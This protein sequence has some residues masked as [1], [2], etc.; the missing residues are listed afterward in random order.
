MGP[1]SQ[2]N[3]LWTVMAS[4]PPSLYLGPMQQFSLPGKQK[5]SETRCPGVAG[6]GASEPETWLFSKRDTDADGRQWMSE[7]IWVMWWWHLESSSQC[8]C[9]YHP[10]Y[11]QYA[12]SDG[13]GIVSTRAVAFWDRQEAPL[14]MDTSRSVF[15]LCQGVPWFFWGKM[16]SSC[17]YSSSWVSYSTAPLAVE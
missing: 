13:S 8:H 3:A 5:A 6:Q 11:P 1:I 15:W 10:W 7:V 17:Q 4:A 16:S 2:L 12:I 9:T 14:C